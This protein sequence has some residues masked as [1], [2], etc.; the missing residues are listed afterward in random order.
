MDEIRPSDWSGANTW[1]KPSLL[2]GHILNMPY[3]ANVG[4][5]RKT[6]DPA[7]TI[8][9][10]KFLKFREENEM[11]RR[12]PGKKKCFENLGITWEVVPLFYVNL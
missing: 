1:A 10:Q 5:M 6:K 8:F 11:E 4:E 7:N 9:N 2:I 12:F 3:T